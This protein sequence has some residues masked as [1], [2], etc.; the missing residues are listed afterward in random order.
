MEVFNNAEMQTAEAI[1][2]QGLSSAA[3]TLSFFM[4][5][6]IVVEQIGVNNLGIADKTPLKLRCTGNAYLLTTEVVGEL[7]GFCCLVFTEEEAE[8]LQ[9]AALPPEVIKDPVLFESMKD[10]ILLEVDNIIAAAVIT[11]FANLLK[12]KM[13][14]SVP[15]LSHIDPSTFEVFIQRRLNNQSHVINF[16]TNFSAK[17]KSFSPMFL[18]FMNEPFINDIKQL[19]AQGQ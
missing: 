4:K 1:I 2:N 15:Q 12:R 14:G 9:K 6:P 10:A 7:E 8:M 19:S 3:E 17:G 18:W 13:H 11:Q 5:E 16:K